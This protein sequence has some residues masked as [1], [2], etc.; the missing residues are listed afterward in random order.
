MIYA[1]EMRTQRAYILKR[2]PAITALI[3]SAAILVGLSAITCDAAQKV[4]SSAAAVRKS[5]AVELLSLDQLKERFQN[6][7]GKVRLI[8]LVSPT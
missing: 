3:V 6:D 1:E 2:W 5:R 7:A 8:V 4:G